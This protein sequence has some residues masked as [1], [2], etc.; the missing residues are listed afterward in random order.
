MPRGWRQHTIGISSGIVLAVWSADR[1]WQRVYDPCAYHDR[2]LLGL[3]GIMSEAELHQIKCGC[4]RRAAEGG[5]SEL[6]VPLPAGLAY[7]RDA[8]C[9]NP[10]KKCTPAA[11]FVRQV[12]RAAQR[13]GG[14]APFQEAN[15][16][17][18]V[19]R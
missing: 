18:P 10:M 12:S 14:D 7:G 19:R 11:P 5:A 15:F 2:L 6:R 8:D 17:V 1:R 13:Q 9:F 16:L 4:I 3:S